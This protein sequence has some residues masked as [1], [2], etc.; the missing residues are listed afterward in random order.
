MGL[1]KNWRKKRGLK[2]IPTEIIYGPFSLYESLK[3]FDEE[4]LVSIKVS[5]K[6]TSQA[7][8]SFY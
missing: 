5:K 1:L 8:T 7:R 2:Y 4:M 6:K 3:T